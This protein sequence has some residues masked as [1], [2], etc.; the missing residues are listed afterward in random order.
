MV[1]GS[2]VLAEDISSYVAER[3][4]AIISPRGLIF[5]DYEAYQ[6]QLVRLGG[7]PR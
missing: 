2:V 5:G 6:Q 4:A 1:E 7:R 3:H